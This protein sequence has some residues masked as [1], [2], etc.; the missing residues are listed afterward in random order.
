MMFPRLS[1]C[2]DAW[3]EGISVMTKDLAGRESALSQIS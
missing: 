1:L 3:G 2:S